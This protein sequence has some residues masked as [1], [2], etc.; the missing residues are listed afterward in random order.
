VKNYSIFKVKLKT[1]NAIKNTSKDSE[2]NY[3]DCM[4]GVVYVI[5]DDPR[6]IYDS[7]KNVIDISFVGIGYSLLDADKAD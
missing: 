3:I 7:F 6:K 5:T 4:D 2:S 1:T